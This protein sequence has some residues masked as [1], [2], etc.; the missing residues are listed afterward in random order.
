MSLS[1]DEVNEKELKQL[2]Y[3]ERLSDNQIADLFRTTRR[4]VAYKRKKLGISI[5]NQTCQELIEQRGE[6]FYKLNADSKERLLSQEN[7]E[8]AAK[9]ITHFIFRNGP[10]EDMHCNHQ[11]TQNDMKTLNKYMVNRIAGLLTAVADH[12]W[13]HLEALL[14]HYQ[15]YGTEWD[16]VEPD[17]EEID[18]V[19]KYVIEDGSRRKIPSTVLG[20]AS[21]KMKEEKC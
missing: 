12:K 2:Y 5:R 21:C 20:R 3:D 10:V 17:M 13:L 9:A 7:I 6:L 16:K 1:W 11:L 4:K 15:L 19:L 18:S 8:T 14:A